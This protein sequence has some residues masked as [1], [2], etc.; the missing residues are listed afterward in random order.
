MDAVCAVAWPS[1]NTAA[2]NFVTDLDEK[3]KAV[4]LV[5][6]GR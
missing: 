1:I 2:G 3:A 6:P 4:R 5:Q